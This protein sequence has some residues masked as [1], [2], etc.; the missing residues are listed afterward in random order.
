MTQKTGAEQRR[1]PRTV[2]GATFD[3]N[4][5]GPA[6]ARCRATITDLSE[7][8]MTF[9]T[10]AELEKGMTL[11]LRLNPDQVV[12][13]GA[14]RQAHLLAGGSRDFLLMDVVPLSLGIETLGGTFNKMIIKN[15]S[16][17]ARVTEEFSTSVDNQTG[18]TLN[19]FQGEREFVADCRKLGQFILKGIPPMPAG[20][21]RVKVTFFV[22]ANGLL[23]VSAKEERSGIEAE[24]EIIPTHGL[25]QAEVSNMIRASME[26]AQEDFEQRTLVEFRAKVNLIAAGMA[27]IWPQ[28][29]TLRSPE[30]L[31]QIQT[32]LEKLT[33]L[34]SHTQNPMELKA[35][36]DQMGN[37][38]RDLADQIM[39][40]AARQA[41]LETKTLP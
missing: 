29:Q 27:K 15:A 4:M 3:I 38:T 26:H 11:H 21:P 32:Q 24:I 28:A 25:K 36:L 23:R 40:E 37:L 5:A 10:D 39:G 7:G 16:I 34:A 9:R 22:D 17:P 35:E 6:A 19:I 13:L 2:V 20:L 1:H 33:A 18:I 41:L 30:E 8:G 14:A 12:A 31:A